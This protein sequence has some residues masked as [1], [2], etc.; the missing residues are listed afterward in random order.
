MRSSMVYRN[1]CKESP[2]VIAENLLA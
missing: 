2:E 1:P